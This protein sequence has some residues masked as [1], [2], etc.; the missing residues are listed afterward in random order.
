M[1]NWKSIAGVCL[2]FVL[3]AVGGGLVTARVIHKRIQH[4]LQGGPQA[5]NEIIVNRLSQKLDLDPAQRAKLKTIVTESHDQIKSVRRQ[6]AP[7]IKDILSDS[8]KKIRGILNPDQEKKFDDVIAK[9]R[10]RFEQRFE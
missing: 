2:V 10:A 7:Q 9:N 3:G 6:I 8:G 4:V 5:I 1:K